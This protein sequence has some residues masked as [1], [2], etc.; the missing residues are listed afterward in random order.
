MVFGRRKGRMDPKLTKLALLRHVETEWNRAKRIQGRLDSPLTPEGVKEA[1]LWADRLA[2]LSWNRIVSSNLGRALNTA[3]IVG[4]V[5]G[6]PVN[7]EPRLVEQDWGRWAGKTVS[8]LAREEPEFLAAAEA[9]GWDFTPP[10]GESRRQILARGLEAL[11]DLV[12]EFPGET[13]LVVTHEGVTKCLIYHLKGRRFL[14]EEPKLIEPRRL[15]WLAGDENGIILDEINVP[16]L[17]PL[18]Q[19]AN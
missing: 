18:E 8:D 7:P 16:L 1:E 9:A 6:L 4:R 13:I 5:L 19:E 3:E 12:R 17:D 11:E 2:G 15:H 14:P 10:G